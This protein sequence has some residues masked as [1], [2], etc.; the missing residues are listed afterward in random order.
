MWGVLSLPL[1]NNRAG[2][3]GLVLKQLTRKN[4]SLSIRVIGGIQ[5]HFSP[6]P[7]FCIRAPNKRYPSTQEPFSPSHRQKGINST[8]PAGLYCHDR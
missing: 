6:I 1:R 8:A 5:P 2:M 3:P 7:D 4:E